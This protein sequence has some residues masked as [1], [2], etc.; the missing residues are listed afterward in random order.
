MTPLGKILVFVNLVFSIA[1]G[2][3]VAAV[4]AN[5]TKFAYELDKSE[6]ARAVERAQAA[7]YKQEA[8][9]VEGKAASQVA[10]VNAQLKKV[11][12][13][14]NAQLALNKDLGEKL[15]AEEKK[16]NKDGAA[17]A[18]ALKEAQVR[19]QDVVT[20]RGTLQA[21]ID[22]NVT[23]T[24]D[25]V[26]LKQDAT[27]DQLLASG[28]LDKNAR[29]EAQMQDLARTLARIQAGG[30]T[31]AVAGANPTGPNPPPENVEGIVQQIDGS[32]GMMKLSIGS[33]AG[34]REGHTLELFRLDRVVPQNSKYLGRV[35]IIRVTATEAVA[36]PVSR[37]SAPVQRNDTV[38]SRL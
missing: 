29:L 5:R 19:Q 22:K 6:K 25:N 20:M 11:Q 18:A 15:L 21:E 30:G 3:L 2:G 27:R 35:R 12:D 8:E 36:Q 23:L 31:T 33:D 16:G 7:T 9:S 28:L 17:L 38:A 24:K 1:V 26:K 4:Y 32:S 10:N 37:L 14:L 13:D 34:L